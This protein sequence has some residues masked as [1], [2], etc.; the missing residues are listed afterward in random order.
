MMSQSE[1]FT[2][3]DVARM[4]GIRTSAIRYYE[5]IGVLPPARRVGGQRRYDA[6]S[7]ALLRVAML[8]GSAG[9][10][11]TEQKRLLRGFDTD[12]PPAE[13]W[14]ALAASKLAELDEIIARAQRMKE[15]VESTLDCTCAEMTECARDLESQW[16]G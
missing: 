7:V 8:A 12:T 5:R 3:G 4:V 13:R 9:F 16:A 11:L 1:P 15:R 14:R 10:S 2:I 6:A